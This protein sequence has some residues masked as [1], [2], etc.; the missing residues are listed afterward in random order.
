MPK[1][2]FFVNCWGSKDSQKHFSVP[3]SMIILVSSIICISQVITQWLPLLFLLH[4][5]ETCTEAIIKMK[6]ALNCNIVS[7]ELLRSVRRMEKVGSRLTPVLIL[8]WLSACRKNKWTCFS[9]LGSILNLVLLN[10]CLVL[11]IITKQQKVNW[12]TFEPSRKLN[13]NT[14]RCLGSR[15][16]P[17]K[18]STE[19]FKKNSHC[20]K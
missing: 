16:Q 6:M 4:E 19:N 3:H 10:K 18:T 12:N 11:K 1:I 9:S 17:N 7:V 13:K 2:K 20:L 15:W 5:F 14:I 8:S